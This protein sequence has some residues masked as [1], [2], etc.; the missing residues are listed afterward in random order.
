L[1]ELAITVAAFLFLCW[2]AIQ[3]FAIICAL[4][5]A[6]KEHKILGLFFLFIALLLVRWWL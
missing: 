4:F 3:G 5:A 6:M 2:V 1:V